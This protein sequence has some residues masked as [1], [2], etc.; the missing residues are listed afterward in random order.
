VLDGGMKKVLFGVITPFFFG[1]AILVLLKTR[2]IVSIVLETRF[3]QYLGKISFSIYLT[4]Q[5]IL[6]VV[7]RVMFRVYSLDVTAINELVIFLMSLM[8]VLGYSSITYKYV[9]KKGVHFLKA[10][11]LK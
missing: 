3:I 11:F 4:H 10:R 1:C 5:L 7:T 2:G 9:E 8:M 6:V